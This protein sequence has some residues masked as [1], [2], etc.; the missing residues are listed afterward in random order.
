MRQPSLPPRHA[1]ADGRRAWHDK[2]RAE[3]RKLY[4][5]KV[6]AYR[7]ARASAPTEAPGD[8][9]EASETWKLASCPGRPVLGNRVKSLGRTRQ[10]VM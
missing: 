1:A 6:S 9:R 8:M 5:A 3:H 4:D 10:P 2:S 7:A